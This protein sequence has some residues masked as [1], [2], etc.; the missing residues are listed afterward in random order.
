MSSDINPFQDIQLS[1]AEDVITVQYKV[2][3]LFPGKA[4]YTFEL[5]AYQDESFVEELYS[6]HGNSY[7]IVD[8]LKMRQNQFPGFFYKLQLTTADNQTYLSNFFGWHPDDS[9]TIHKYLLASD[10]SRRER[11]RFNYTGLYAYLLKRKMYT[12]TNPA[13]M[14]PVTGEPMVDNTNTFGTTGGYYSPLL[15]RFSIEGRQTQTTLDEGGRG[16]QFVE[17]LNIRSVGF[18]Y[19]DQHDII[20]TLDGKR[21]T[22]T[23]AN[24]KY[25]PGTTMI[26][27]QT[28]ALRLIPNTDTIYSIT[29][30]KFTNEL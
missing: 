1:L 21:Y 22:V 8:N 10:I 29:I 2:F 24:N 23:E 20:A 16:S 28:P 13:L 9:V 3:P 14:D 18:P 12:V 7:F 4:P 17:M 15:T 6:I 5:I 26:L 11:I 19:I 25:F 27:L 30:P